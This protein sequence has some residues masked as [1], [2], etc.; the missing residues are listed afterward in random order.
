V[1]LYGLWRNSHALV[2]SQ[3]RSGRSHVACQ[4]CDERFSDFKPC[5]MVHA[6]QLPKENEFE[7]VVASRQRQYRETLSALPGHA[8]RELTWL[9]GLVS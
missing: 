3:R 4:G 7:N 9:P 8:G 1:S 6:C 2:R 5:S